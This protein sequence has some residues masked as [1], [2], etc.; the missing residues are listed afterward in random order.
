MDAAIKSEQKVFYK[1]LLVTVLPLMLQSLFMQS[2]SFIDQL[3]ISDIGTDAVGAIGAAN[4]IMSIYN[5]FLY[6]ACSGCS[7]FLAQYWG[8]KDTDGFRKMFGINMISTVTVGMVFTVLI[9]LIPEFLLGL[10]TDDINVIRLGKDYI[11]CV[12][13]SYFLMGII[14][15]LNYCLQSMNH[16]RVTA[17]NTMISVFVNVSVNYVLIFGKFGFPEMGVKGAALGT[18]ATRAVEL[19]VLLCYFAVTKCIALWEHHGSFGISRVYFYNYIKKA[20]PLIANEMFW[21]LGTSVYFIVYGKNGSDALAAM[22]ILQ[23]WQMLS[24][25]AALAFCH[26]AAIII[27]NEI[28]YGDMDRVQRYC[29]RFHG[30]A[31]AVGLVSAVFVIAVNKP[32]LAIYHIEGTEVGRIVSNCMYILALY[33]ILNSCNCINVEG[34]FRSGGDVKY[35]ALMDLGSIWIIGMP[36]TLITGLVLHLD[37]VYIYMAYIM[38]ELYKLP[39]GHMRFKSGKWLHR[40]SG[41]NTEEADGQEGYSE[42]KLTG[43]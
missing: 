30:I 4:K 24:R 31:L 3:M 14:Y 26:A 27:G 6:G 38:L 5:S 34:I 41:N 7:M 42:Y 37:V 28:G 12:A 29:K 15:P 22:S 9:F 17:V 10:F 19:I 35:I 25:I 1:L 2:I 33:V 11:I 23:I 40:L 18:V 16:V 32:M 36:Y 43:S 21:S 13:V 20:A 39:L 8:N